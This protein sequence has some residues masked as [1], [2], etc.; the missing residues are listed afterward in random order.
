MDN[1]MC[2]FFRLISSLIEK[3]ADSILNIDTIGSTKI[4]QHIESF[5]KSSRISGLFEFHKIE[6]Y[7]IMFRLGIN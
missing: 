1:I 7:V 5:I 2:N 4:V 6:P 3:I